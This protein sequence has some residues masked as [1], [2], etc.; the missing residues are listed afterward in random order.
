M[1]G[2]AEVIPVAKPPSRHS[3]FYP[4]L[5][6]FPKEFRGKVADECEKFREQY[7]VAAYFAEPK[8]LS[9]FLIIRSAH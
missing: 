1:V 9:I 3:R 4:R 8:T 7:R 5:F 6:S 2:N